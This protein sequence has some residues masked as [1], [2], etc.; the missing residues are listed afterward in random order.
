[1]AKQV[2]VVVKPIV[3]V[4]LPSGLS[5]PKSIPCTPQIMK[6]KMSQVWPRLFATWGHAIL[7]AVVRWETF[8]LTAKLNRLLSPIKE[9]QA[10]D[11][12]FCDITGSH[13]SSDHLFTQ[14]GSRER[15]HTEIRPTSFPCNLPPNLTMQPSRCRSRTGPTW[16]KFSFPLNGGLE[17]VWN[18]SR[19]KNQ[20]FTSPSH[21]S[22]QTKGCL[23]SGRGASSCKG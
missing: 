3:T 23:T 2:T 9:K 14:P 19:Y 10:V 13:S 16:F 7:L 6:E 5:K 22:K 18:P 21:Q 17:G 11:M 20:G 4:L 12:V 1:M 15:Y 8:Q